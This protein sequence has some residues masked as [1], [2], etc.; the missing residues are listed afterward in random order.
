[1]DEQEPVQKHA[2]QLIPFTIHGTCAQC[3][4]NSCRGAGCNPSTL[5]A[6]ALATSVHVVLCILNNEIE[7][8]RMIG[9][10][11][12]FEIFAA[13]GPLVTGQLLPWLDV[14]Q[15]PHVLT[16]ALTARSHPR[17]NS[18]FIFVTSTRLCCADGMVCVSIV[19]YDART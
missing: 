18:S 7:I 19:R 13:L 5:L 11:Y 9:L 10:G 2:S 6:F 16:R 8:Q 14:A 17:Q 15:H 4:H 1:M 3:S 12:C